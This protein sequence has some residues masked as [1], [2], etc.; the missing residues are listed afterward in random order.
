MTTWKDHSAV[1]TAYRLTPK[2]R[3]IGGYRLVRAGAMLIG[4]AA[5]GSSMAK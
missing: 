3:D 1:A 5:H 2:F 4:L